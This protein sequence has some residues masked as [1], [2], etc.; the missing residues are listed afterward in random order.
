MA[1]PSNRRLVTESALAETILDLE[2]SGVP[3]ATGPQGPKGDP[4]NTGPQGPQGAVGP[5]GNTGN[6]GPQG[7]AGADGAAGAQGPQGVQGPKGDKGDAGATGPQGPQGIQGIQGPQ[8]PA[9]TGEGG[10]E[11]IPGPEGPQGP[12]GPQ[13]PEGPA[14]PQG[15]PGVDGA[16]GIQGPSGAPGATG[17][18]GA[19][20]AQGEP[21]EDGAQ[22][23]QGVAGPQGDPG[24]TGPAGP[25]GTTTVAG[26][27]DASV[28]GKT[29]ATAPS[30]S[31]ARTAIAAAN[32]VDMAAA[33]TIL[34]DTRDPYRRAV[35]LSLP[36]RFPGYA[37]VL[38]AKSYTYLFPQGFCYDTAANQLFIMYGSSNSMPWISVHN[39]T[40]GAYI[41]GFSL[42]RVFGETIK[43]ITIGAARYLYMTS[44]SD[45]CRWTIT[46]LPANQA[47]VAPST[48]YSNLNAFSHFTYQAGQFTV[49]TRGQANGGLVKH[50]FTRWNEALTARQGEVRMDPADQWTIDAALIPLNPKAQNMTAFRDGYATV[51]GGGHV[52]GTSVWAPDKLHGVKT[53]DQY[54]NVT[55]SGLCDPNKFAQVLIDAGHPVAYLEAEGIADYNGELHALWCTNS[56]AD[57][58]AADT[59][60][61][62]ITRELGGPLDFRGAAAAPVRVPG[63]TRTQLAIHCPT[64][65]A[66]NSPIDGAAIT[67]LE[68]VIEMMRAANLQAFSFTTT[69]VTMADINGANLAS[70]M[71]VEIRTA[72]FFSWDVACTTS[73]TRYSYWV[74][75]ASGSLVQT[76]G[77]NLAVTPAAGWT[78]GG[79]GLTNAIG[80]GV[81][82][83]EV[84][85]LIRTASLTP[86][87]STGDVSDEDVLTVQAAHRPGGT[88]YGT[89]TSNGV[90]LAM[91]A[92]LNTGVLRLLGF[93]SKPPSAITPNLSGTFVYTG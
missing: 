2:V 21:G 58:P 73:T 46:A 10:G 92:L 56:H 34:T 49:Q 69:G 62:L 17:P 36:I 22:G 9:G 37:T 57:T 71:F 12:A 13:G 72:N 50:W 67:T 27:S 19:T 23:P 83:L 29:L 42:D 75:G 53:L 35:L 40:T 1:Q 16:P 77:P 86:N 33:Q 41:S 28:L 38:A 32:A 88:R 3:G 44:G 26:L 25:A 65:G 61:I 80:G 8:G 6:T 90:H 18:A 24:D 31:A 74:A 39:A 54:G 85:G 59:R 64:G 14:G 66:L 76:G 81:Y 4:G 30:A 87:A 20:G 60:G 11:P 79:G 70:G 82:A 89:I 78:A 55:A 51:Y 84:S 93:P 5:K 48:V 43:V 91:V 7:P 63:Q 68:G 52:P 45:M 47:T 15:D